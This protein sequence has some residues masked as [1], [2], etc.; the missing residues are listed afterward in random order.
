MKMARSFNNCGRKVRKNGGRVQR[1]LA[2]VFLLFFEGIS[3]YYIFFY[4]STK[5]LG[6]IEPSN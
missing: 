3:G 5:L 6:I 2:V 4:V 1:E